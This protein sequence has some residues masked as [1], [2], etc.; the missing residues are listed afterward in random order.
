MANSK[1]EWVVNRSQTARIRINGARPFQCQQGGDPGGGGQSSQNRF[2]K[3]RSIYRVDN[4]PV[5]EG[6]E[7]RRV[8]RLKLGWEY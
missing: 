5:R 3:N 7:E 2:W 4:V 8:R 6:Q 1:V